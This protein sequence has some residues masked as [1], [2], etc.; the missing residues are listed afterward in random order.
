[1]TDKNTLDKGT[2][3]ST[4]GGQLVKNHSQNKFPFSVLLVQTDTMSK[5]AVIINRLILI[6]LMSFLS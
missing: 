1:M 2:S 3:T 4:E 6:Y 5:I